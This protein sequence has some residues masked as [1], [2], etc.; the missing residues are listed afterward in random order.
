MKSYLSSQLCNLYNER[1]AGNIIAELF[2]SYKNWNRADIL[3]NA[4]SRISESEMLQFHFAAKRLAQGEPLQYIVG[5]TWFRGLEIKVNPGVL[6]PRPETEELVQ[7]VLNKNSFVSPRILDIG[8][9][10]GCIA[11]ALKKEIPNADVSAIDISENA[12]LTA[13]QNAE[14]NK[15]E[16][17]FIHQDILN[18]NLGAN[19]YDV[20]VSNP[21]YIPLREKSAMRKQVTEHE[22]NLALFVPDENALLFYSK[23]IHL[24]KTYLSP[25]GKV[26]CEIHEGME[27]ALK[28]EF[29]KSGIT[30]FEF[31]QDMQG[32]TRMF[33]FSL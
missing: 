9:G 13:K 7:L 16:I 3:L 26:F 21:P 8:T 12:L 4:N 10:S 6:I 17:N 20:I 14:L 25:K 5:H 32:K 27:D 28:I 18:A 31:F 19:R 22:P 30:M 23:I 15:A 1:E 24:A 11:I 29:E 2:R 33:Y